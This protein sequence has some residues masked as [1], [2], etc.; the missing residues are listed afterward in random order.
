M[1]RTRF[2]TAQDV[3]EELGVSLSYA[4]KL[5]R[6]LNAEREEQGFV[7]I[8][9]RVSRRYFEERIYGITDKSGVV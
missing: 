7:T 9:G 2:V 3:E 1:A 4:Y 5:I 6:R 8:K